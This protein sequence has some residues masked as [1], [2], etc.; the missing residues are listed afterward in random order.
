[1]PYIKKKIHRMILNVLIYRNLEYLDCDGH[2][3]YFIAKLFKVLMEEKG[4]SYNHAKEFIGE[5]ECSKMEIYRRWVQPYEDE[6][7]KENG[8]VE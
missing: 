3:N 7:I 1:M 8:D 5:L 2:L 6:K 4:M